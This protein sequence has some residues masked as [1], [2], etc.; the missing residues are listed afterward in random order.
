[1]RPDGW[2][3]IHLSLPPQH[4]DESHVTVCSASYVGIGDQVLIFTTASTLP[5]E[6]SPQFPSARIQRDIMQKPS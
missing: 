6:P 2:P 4:W 5:K 3:G 1:M